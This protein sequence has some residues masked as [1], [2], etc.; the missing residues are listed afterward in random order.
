LARWFSD[1]D[2]SST[3]S[4]IGGGLEHTLRG[5]TNGVY[6]TEV[7]VWLIV[8]KYTLVSIDIGLSGSSLIGEQTTFGVET[9]S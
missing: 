5:A 3:A 9:W 6:A 7:H 1:K 2:Y 8:G 4:G